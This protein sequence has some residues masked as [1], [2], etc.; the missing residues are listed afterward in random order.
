MPKCSAEILFTGEI[1]AFPYL[2]ILPRP[3]CVIAPLRDVD[4]FVLS[5]AA[6]CSATRSAPGLHVPLPEGVCERRASR[7]TDQR[8]PTVV[9]A[10][11]SR[12]L[13]TRDR[14]VAGVPP[15]PISSQG[16]W[17]V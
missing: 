9:A 13:P 15:A 6:L 14:H 7:Q 4:G 1:Y 3:K 2:R 11:R 16:D 8:E 5:T 10:I 12:R 17:A